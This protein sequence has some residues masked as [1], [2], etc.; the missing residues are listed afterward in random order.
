[1]FWTKVVEEKVVTHIELGYILKAEPR[2][3]PGHSDTG[4]ERKRGED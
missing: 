2:G 4:S 3:F 1:M